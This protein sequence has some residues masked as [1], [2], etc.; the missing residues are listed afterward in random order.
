M[1]NKTPYVSSSGTL[2]SQPLYNRIS[3]SASD[4]ATIVY[5][6][7]ETLISPIANP[8]SW[9]DPS[10]RPAQRAQRPAGR[11]GGG[12]GG[13]NGPRPGGAGGSGFMTMGDLRGGETVDGCRATCG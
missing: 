9:T 13:G 4:I 7:F 3:N 5:L 12:G 8:A 6:F 2:T 10:S 1:S 11:S